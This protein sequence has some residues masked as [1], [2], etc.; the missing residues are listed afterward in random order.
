MVGDFVF[1]RSGFGDGDYLVRK[2]DLRSQGRGNEIINF[3]GA[4]IISSRDSSPS[5]KGF[6]LSGEPDDATPVKF[7]GTYIGANH[8]AF[9]GI[10]VPVSDP[11]EVGSKW[12]DSDGTVFS[13]IQADT[14]S[15]TFISSEIGKPGEWKFKLAIAG[16]LSEIGGSRSINVDKQTRAQ[17]YPSVRRLSK[18]VDAGESVALGRD[19]QRVQKLIVGE[20][21]EIL[22]PIEPRNPVAKVDVSYT[23][24]GSDTQVHTTVKAY[25]DLHDFSIAGTQTGPINFKHT[26]LM[27]KVGDGQWF[28]IS[29]S[30]N[31]VRLEGS[32]AMQMVAGPEHEYGVGIGVDQVTINGKPVQPSGIVDLSAARKQYPLAIYPGVSGFSGTLRAGEQAS[33]TAHRSYWVPK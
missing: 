32:D 24:I 12:S 29:E 9:F 3:A 8:G 5:D 27:Q 2:L 17:I 18:T 7:N 10:T 33:V 11:P 22:S 25:Q 23:L 20:S 21:Y 14:K 1:V 15:A 16:R 4:R 19:F 6:L 13:V 31:P 26:K 30:P 28:D